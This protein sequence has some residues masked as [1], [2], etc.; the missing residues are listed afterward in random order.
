MVTMRSAGIKLEST[1]EQR[2][3]ARSGAAPSEYEPQRAAIFDDVAISGEMFS[4]LAIVSRVRI[5]FEV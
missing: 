3:L 1:F 4:L 5:V 2:R